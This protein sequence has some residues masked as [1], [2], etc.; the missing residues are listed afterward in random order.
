M[1][2]NGIPL[3][4]KNNKNA[5]RKMFN[6]W[7]PPTA[8]IKVSPGTTGIAPF[9]VYFDAYESYADPECGFGC[10]IVSYEWNFGDGGTGT[11]ITINHTYSNIGS[12]TVILAVTDNNGKKGYDNL[13]ITVT[14]KPTAKIT[15]VPPAEDGV[16]TGISP[17]KVYFLAYQSTSESGI[18]TYSW[19]FGDGYTGTGITTY[20]TYT[21]IGSYII[22][23]TVTDYNG[24]EG[25][26]YITITVS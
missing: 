23:L 17:F 14:K 21:D 16:V 13:E 20:H 5:I 24:Y 11:G 6:K 1:N 19:D 4:L 18:V 9:E 3:K 7:I 12:Y 2:S 25:F 15:T 8:I 26:D 22:Y 10:E